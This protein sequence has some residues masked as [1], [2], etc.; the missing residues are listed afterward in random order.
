MWSRGNKQVAQN[1]AKV[2]GI[3]RAPPIDGYTP[4]QVGNAD[5]VVLVGLD[6][7]NGGVTATP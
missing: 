5:A 6:I 4:D 2:L 1:V 3:K 7:A